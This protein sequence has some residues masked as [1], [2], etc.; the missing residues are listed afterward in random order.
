[1]LPQE[2]YIYILCP[3]FIDTLRRKLSSIADPKSIVVSATTSPNGDGLNSTLV[4]RQSGLGREDNSTINT[5]VKNEIGPHIS[6]TFSKRK[7]SVNTNK[8]ES[9]NTGKEIT[10]RKSSSVAK[11]GEANSPNVL[12]SQKSNTDD[13][14]SMY[15]PTAPANGR[16][17]GRKMSLLGGAVPMTIEKKK[18]RK[19]SS[20]VIPE[21]F[22]D[23]SVTSKSYFESSGKTT[24]DLKLL[25]NKL[26]STDEKIIYVSNKWR[27][28]VEG[29]EGGVSMLL[30]TV[31]ETADN[32]E[33]NELQDTGK[34]DKDI[35][36]CDSDQ[37]TD[38]IMDKRGQDVV[39]KQSEPVNEESV[40]STPQSSGIS[41][42]L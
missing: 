29:N 15:K 36:A 38:A 14:L 10:K 6:H 26:S 11:K 32:E 30:N 19:R 8:L 13:K 2:T 4:R 28:G 39:K 25:E 5:L 24:A 21:I 35:N 31:S 34:F 33:I 23:L 16:T 27:S 40:T 41:F 7:S 3:L 20:K 42:Y 22:A 1:M 37:E 9:S 12:D 17:S 18:S